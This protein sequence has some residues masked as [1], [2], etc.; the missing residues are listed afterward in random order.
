MLHT[1][2]QNGFA[3]RTQDP[4]VASTNPRKLTLPGCWAVTV[5]GRVLDLA[6]PKVEESVPLNGGGA[7]ALSV[8]HH[9]KGLGT[10]VTITSPLVTVSGNLVCPILTST[11]GLS[12]TGC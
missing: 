9:Q 12:L 4:V 8:S 3:T 7:V 11:L 5:D 10:V 1:T 6:V 2:P